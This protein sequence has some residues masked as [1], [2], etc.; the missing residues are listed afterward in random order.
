MFA[1]VTSSITKKDKWDESIKRM[2]ESIWPLSKKQ[3]GYKGFL[4]LFNPE[5]CEGI[6]ISLWD[7]EADMKAT[8]TIYQGVIK[9]VKESGVSP[10]GAKYYTVGIKD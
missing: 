5:T 4:F 10:S 2:N 3:K 1:R 6:T 9:Q 8:G 7:T